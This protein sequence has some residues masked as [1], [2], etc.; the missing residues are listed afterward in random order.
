MVITE[1]NIFKDRLLKSYRWFIPIADNENIKENIR[2]EA[3]NYALEVAYA[4]L[5]LEREGAKVLG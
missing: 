4:L 3:Q 5:K 1:K 2:L